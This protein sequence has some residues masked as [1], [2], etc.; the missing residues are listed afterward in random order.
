MHQIKAGDVIE[1]RYQVGRLIGSGGMATVYEVHEM[2]TGQRFAMKVLHPQLLLHNVIPQRFLR[3]AQ[4]ARALQTPHAVRFESTGNLHDG[5]PYLVMEYLEGEPLNHV[6]ARESGRM[7]TERVLYI[8]DQVA[9]GIQDA[10]DRGVIHRDLKPENVFVIPTPTGEL[11]KIVDFGISKIF[12]AEDGVKLT[13]TGVTV[14]TP[15]Y[16]PVEQLRGTKGLDGRVDVYALGV[17]LYEMLAGVR[18]F[19]GF[20]YQEVILKVATSKA[21]PLVSYR[22]DLPAGLAEIV[23]RALARDRDE[24]IG[25]MAELRQVIAPYWSGASPLR[26]TAP[27]GAPSVGT[28][29]ATAVLATTGAHPGT[30]PST[31][32]DHVAPLAQSGAYPGALGITGGYPAG[33]PA[34]TVPDM[35]SVAGDAPASPVAEVPRPTPTKRAGLGALAIVIVVLMVVAALG[36][37]LLLGGAGVWLYVTG[38]P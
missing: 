1:Q 14:G 15:Q 16:M 29:G 18:P 10:H 23:D 31:I 4:A 7:S 3:E 24:R 28:K 19:D 32:P 33:A 21:P 17:I 12:S 37:I 38:G 8:A 9:I 5:T 26:T 34:R 13:Q 35:Q 11:V 27:A 30:P 6:I 25:S 20:T 22:S 36:V 2:A